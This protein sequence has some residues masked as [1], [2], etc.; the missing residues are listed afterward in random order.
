MLHENYCKTGLTALIISTTLAYA[1]LSNAVIAPYNQN[2]YGLDA[3]DPNVIGVDQWLGFAD[4]WDGEVGTGTFLYNYGAF[5]AP[6]GTPGF[7]SI[8]FGE[9][10]GDAVTDQY[11]NIYSDYDNGDHGNGFNINTS[12]FHE[13]TL[14]AADVASGTWVF[15]GDYKAPLLDGIADPVSNATARVFIKT[16]DPN[17]GYSETNLITFDVTDASN[18]DW[19]SF[20]KSIDLSNPLLEGQILQFGFNTV[21]TNYED[22]G[23]YYDNLCFNN[24]GSCYTPPV[25]PTPSPPTS[26]SSGAVSL[27]VLVLFGLIGFTRRMKA[28]R[29]NQY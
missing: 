17:D 15:S 5:A 10:Q 4:V 20:S 1:P 28:L 7:S 12:V 21:A 25:A 16:L 3:A 18:T 23:V 13:H 27:I 9:G 2:F 19:K 8:S 14:D 22:S 24:D 6:N 26:S 11:L 29:V